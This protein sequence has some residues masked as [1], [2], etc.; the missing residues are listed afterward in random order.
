MRGDQGKDFFF[1]LF[2]TLH[3][4]CNKGHCTC[5][6]LLALNCHEWVGPGAD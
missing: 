1:F 4:R 6:P 2:H 3:C 5:N